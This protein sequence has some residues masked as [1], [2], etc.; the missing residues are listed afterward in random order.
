MEEQIVP[1]VPGRKRH[2][3][4]QQR[5]AAALL[6]RR[7]R[8]GLTPKTERAARN[9]SISQAAKMSEATAAARGQADVLRVERENR[10]GRSPESR[11]TQEHRQAL[12]PFL[13]LRGVFKA[14]GWGAEARM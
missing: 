8:T 14:K 3:H 10:N 2:D 11:Q 1:G 5:Y 12:T 13:R 6:Y 7:N 9:M 4:T